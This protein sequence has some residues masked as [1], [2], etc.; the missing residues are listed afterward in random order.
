MFYCPSRRPAALYAAPSSLINNA[1]PL[2]PAGTVAKTD[3][4]GNGGSVGFNLW[5]KCNGVDCTSGSSVTTG[6]LLG[7]DVKTYFPVE[8]TTISANAALA[9]SATFQWYI[10]PCNAPLVGAKKAYCPGVSTTNTASN[11]SFTGVIWYRSQVSMRQISDGTSKVYLIG[12]KYL[13]QFSA[14][15]TNT[16]YANGN[17]DEGSLY[18]GMCPALIRLAASGGAYTPT[19]PPQAATSAGTAGDPTKQYLYPPKQDSPIWPG[20]MTGNSLSGGGFNPI[21][22]G[23][24]QDWYGYFSFGSAH[25]GG[26]N[27]AFC[28]GSV[29]TILYEIDPAV[30]A[31]L[32]D[33]QDGLAF[34]ASQ[35][36]PQ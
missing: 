6:G 1:T 24:L 33:R 35:Y 26:F 32:S 9:P 14:T 28:D 15:A 20:E 23:A 19:V 36:I 29:H 7:N 2:G 17:G 34:D 3:Y 21:P 10:P 12:E 18:H 11:V 13:D 16:Q 8:S 5:G 27:M 22:A 31:M 25:A 4:A 30:H